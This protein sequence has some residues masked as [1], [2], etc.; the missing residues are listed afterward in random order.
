MRQSVARVRGRNYFTG[1]FRYRE[2]QWSRSTRPTCRPYQIR[3]KGHNL[4]S[5]EGKKIFRAKKLIVPQLYLNLHL[6]L[7]KEEI[8]RV[9]TSLGKCAN[10][11]YDQ[12]C[13]I[14]LPAKS[15][16]TQLVIAHNHVNSGHMS[17]NHTRS[18]LRN[19]FWIPKDTPIIKTVLKKCQ[20][21]FDQRG[22]RYH[23]PDSPDFPE[24]K[25]D[26]KNPWKT[27]FLDMTGHF[28]H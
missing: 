11:T 3:V 18:K 25:F 13:P 7:D 15:V 17:I 2:N 16:Y 22:Q 26:L 19:R 12:I 1:I 4:R 6:I 9:K 10:L 5:L 24:F 21:C 14:L 27:T 28:F 23:V 8:I 20:V